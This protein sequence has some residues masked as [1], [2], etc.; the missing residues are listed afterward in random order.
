MTAQSRKTLPFWENVLD[1]VQYAVRPQSWYWCFFL[2]ICA[3]FCY[4]FIF[5][6]IV[7]LCLTYFFVCLFWLCLFFVKIVLVRFYLLMVPHSKI[8]VNFFKTFTARIR[9][10]IWMRAFCF[11]LFRQCSGLAKSRVTLTQSQ[12]WAGHSVKAT[13]AFKCRLHTL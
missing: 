4:S 2:H 13:A 11:C 8:V 3:L 1:F 12:V 5:C 7:F 6:F 10:I 9:V